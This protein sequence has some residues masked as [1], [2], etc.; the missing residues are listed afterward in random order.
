MSS[1]QRLPE[2]KK[3][4]AQRYRSCILLCE[5]YSLKAVLTWSQGNIMRLEPESQPNRL[6][7]YLMILCRTRLSSYASISSSVELKDV[8]TFFFS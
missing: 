6:C 2:A 8:L 7:I 5:I 4:V 1:F 3:S